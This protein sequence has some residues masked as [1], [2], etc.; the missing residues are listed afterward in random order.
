MK[1][2]H[3]LHVYTCKLY[4]LIAQVGGG[5]QWMLTKIRLVQGHRSSGQGHS[6]FESI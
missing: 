3:E 1:P 5:G 6:H 4:I 2:F